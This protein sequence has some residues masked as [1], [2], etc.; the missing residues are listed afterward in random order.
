MVQLFSMPPVGQKFARAKAQLKRDETIR[1]LETVLSALNDYDPKAI[2][3]QVRFEI[4]VLITECVQDLNRQPAVRNLFQTL[5]KSQKA[6]IPYMPGEEKRLFGVLGIVYKAL[7]E[8]I[9][10]TEENAE[11]QK[12][13]RKN[14]LQQRG[15]EYLRAG[16][17]PRGRA[18][19]RLL[20]EEFGDEPGMLAQVGEWFIE[21]QLYFEAAAVLEQSI[22]NFPKDRKAYSLATKCYTELREN[23]KTEAIYLK[24][25]KQFGKHPRTLL[26]LA[27]FYMSCNKKEE[28]FRAAQ[29]AYSKDSSLTEAKEIVDKY[30]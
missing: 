20:A 14:S 26:N 2:S 15:L 12:L 13:E 8:S 19:L 30:A 29:E 28:A 17:L 7:S 18:S 27:K 6:Y 24:A 1:A 4:E 23:E 3:S 21:F 9:K 22:E 5:V 25:I 16:D 11:Q 10:A